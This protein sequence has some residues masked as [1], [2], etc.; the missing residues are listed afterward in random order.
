MKNEDPWNRLEEMPP[1]DREKFTK[2]EIAF[3]AIFFLGVIAGIII[4]AIKIV[5]MWLELP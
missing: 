1:R 3:W 5:S 4:G 2:G